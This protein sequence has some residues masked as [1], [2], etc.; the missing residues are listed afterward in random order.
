[1]IGFSPH[2]RVVWQHGKLQEHMMIKTGCIKMKLLKL[3]KSTETEIRNQHTVV[4]DH[5][6]IVKFIAVTVIT[7]KLIHFSSNIPKYTKKRKKSTSESTIM[8]FAHSQRGGALNPRFPTWG[9]STVKGAPTI[10]RDVQGFC[11]L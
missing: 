6:A 8:C 5:E 2:P 3:M 10:T 1:M 9:P 11:L 4:N 7:W